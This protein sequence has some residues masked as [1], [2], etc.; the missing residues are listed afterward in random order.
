MEYIKFEDAQS[1]V[2]K[3]AQEFLTYSE[4]SK[5]VHISLSGG[6]TPKLLFKTLAETDYADTINWNNLHFW[7]GDE[8]CV[9]PDNEESNYGEVQRL[10]FD[11]I[12]IP[13]ENIH[14]IHGEDDPEQEAK[15]F[16]AE[17]TALV[18]KNAAGVPEFDWIILG[19]GTDGHTASLFPLQVDLENHELT[20][21]SK[22]PQSGQLRVSKS[23]YLIENAKRVTYLVTGASK[24]DLL[25]E[26]QQTD[27]SALPY[28]AARIKSKQGKT[29]WYLDADAASQL[30]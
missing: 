2:E 1:A 9:A 7:W 14:R 3:I 23:A 5:P 4:Q 22:Q 16:A 10:L 19:M 20:I 17:M 29:E 25:H 27:S 11:H 28:P 18:P 6:S 12:E 15:R 26:I 8:R 21:V 30:Q 24:A 13:A